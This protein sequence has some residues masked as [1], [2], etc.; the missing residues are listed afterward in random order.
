MGGGGHFSSHPPTRGGNPFHTHLARR[1]RRLNPAQALAAG[2]K[3]LTIATERLRYL[4]LTVVQTKC[5][6]LILL[7]CACPVY[8]C[9]ICVYAIR[10]SDRNFPINT[11]LLSYLT[12]QMKSVMCDADDL[13]HWLT[14]YRDQLKSSTSFSAHP[15]VMHQQQAQFLVISLYCLHTYRALLL[16]FLIFLVFTSRLLTSESNEHLPSNVYIRCWD[17]SSTSESYT[18]YHFV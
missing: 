3:I 16:C 8:L 15:D 5:C 9:V 11:Y 12:V 10:S 14:S 4:L 13:S 6:V 1:L 7:V 18:T 17:I 2:P